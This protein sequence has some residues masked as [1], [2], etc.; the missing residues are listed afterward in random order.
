MEVGGETWWLGYT[1]MGRNIDLFTASFL[2]GSVVKK[3]KSPPAVQDMQIRSLGWE[4]TQRRKWQ[5][6]PVILPGKSHGQWSLVGYGP[7]AHKESGMT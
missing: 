6:T 4:D 3:K 1:E 7:R 2:G 5:P